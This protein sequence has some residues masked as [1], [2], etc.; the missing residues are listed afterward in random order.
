MGLNYSLRITFTNEEDAEFCSEEFYNQKIVLPDGSLVELFPNV[1]EHADNRKMTDKLYILSVSINGLGNVGIDLN[2]FKTSNFYTVRD[3]F[4]QYLKDIKMD[5]KFAHFELEAAD[6][7]M[8]AEDMTDDIA[9]LMK[10]SSVVDENAQKVTGIG[11]SEFLSKRYIDGFIISLKNYNKL[12]D[13]RSEF[14]IFKPD[15]F[16]LPLKE[17]K[18]S[19]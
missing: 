13:G 11:T 6:Y 4:Y 15:Y 16:W 3:F 14:L 17:F 9:F 18:F 2:L 1:Y 8:C 7:L 19:K 12:K 10:N 5:F